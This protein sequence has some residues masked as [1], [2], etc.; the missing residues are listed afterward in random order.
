MIVDNVTPDVL[1]AFDENDRYDGEI[2]N[3]NKI[4]SSILTVLEKHDIRKGDLE[5]IF[6]KVIKMYWETFDRVIKQVGYSYNDTL[7]ECMTIAL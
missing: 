2:E 5:V 6:Q 3:V 4:Q 1:K 7:D